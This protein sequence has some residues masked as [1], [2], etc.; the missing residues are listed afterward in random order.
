MQ[1]GRRHM[2]LTAQDELA[3]GDYTGERHGNSKNIYT[4]HLLFLRLD[5]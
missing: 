3:E 2:N 4:K 1:D 5:A